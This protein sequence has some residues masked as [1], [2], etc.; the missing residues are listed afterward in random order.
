MPSNLGVH[1]SPIRR[2]ARDGQRGAIGSGRAIVV[3]GAALILVM[4]V[5]QTGSYR[6]AKASTPADQARGACSHFIERETRNPRSIEH[7]DYERWT[8]MQQ[9]ATSW[10]V[11]GLY[12]ANN[13]H[14]QPAL[15]TTTCIVRPDGSD[16]SLVAIHTR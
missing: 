5:G 13:A 11:I 9:D 14:G 6:D 4:C 8:V 15:Y 2:T 10:N 3:G 7:I 12:R 1:N 16:W